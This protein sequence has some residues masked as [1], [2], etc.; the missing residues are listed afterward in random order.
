MNF[1]AVSESLRVSPRLD[2]TKIDTSDCTT[3]LALS[4]LASRYDSV[5]RLSRPA[6]LISSDFASRSINSS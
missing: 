4:G 1:L 5:Y 6:F 2:S 3:R